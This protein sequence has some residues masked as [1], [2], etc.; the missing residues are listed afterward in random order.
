MRELVSAA[1]ERKIAIPAQ[2]QDV[3][4]TKKVSDAEFVWHEIHDMTL[5]AASRTGSKVCLTETPAQYKTVKRTV[6]TTPAST[7]T[8]EIPA[9]YKT[10]KVRKLVSAAEERRIAIPEERKTVTTRELEK[11]GY[12]E[13]RSILCETNATTDLVRRLQSTLKTKGHNPGA[14][15]GVVGADTI[16]AVNAYQAA[17]NLPVDRYLNIETLKH[18]GVL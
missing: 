15:D 14:I 13:W 10:V 12:M 3:T 18:M 17:N 9:E 16:R 11:D 8:V 7:R 2:Y 4:S 6:I 5:S 1:S